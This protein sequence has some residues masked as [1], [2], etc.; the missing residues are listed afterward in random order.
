MSVPVK[1][2]IEN[3]VIRGLLAAALALPY[4]WRVPLFG[5][6]TSRVIAPVAGWTKRIRDNLD[7]VWPEL[8]QSERARLYREVPDNVGRTLIEI[9]SGQEFIDRT[10][11]IPPTGAGVE[12]IA[13]AH[14]AKRPVILIT[15]HFGNYD[16]VRA[17][18]TAHGYPVGALYRPMKN[19]LFNAH[20]ESAISKIGSP[21]FP[22]GPR[23]LASMVRHLRA[24]GWLG[25]LLDANMDHGAP[26][27]FFGKP[28]LTALSAAEMALKYDALLV[29]TYGIR[30]A[31][32][33]G[34]EIIV[35]APIPHSTPE[36]MT[37]ALNDSLEALVRQYPGQWFWVHRRWKGGLRKA[38][39]DSL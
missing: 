3:V 12:A 11:A 19:V 23:G 35:E 37:Q 31:D 10:S 34:F 38:S 9:Y 22:R 15:G 33:L 30:Q 29:P 7:L 18:M 21:I 24:G 20:Y 1:H 39:Q 5:W 16:A 14:A 25:M 8:P 17:A 13:E 2:R 27:S 28:A 26:L 32:G 36:A 4:R 6:V